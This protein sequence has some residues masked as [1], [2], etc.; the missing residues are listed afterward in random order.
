MAAGTTL[1]YFT[2]TGN[3]LKVARDVA[4]ELGDA[5]LISIPRAGE[6]TVR[7]KAER[8]GIVFPTYFGG[9][10]LIVRSFIERLETP[11]YVFA[12]TT[13]GG[14]SGGSLMQADRLL[15]A[16]GIHLAAGFA[17]NM[18]GNYT[19]LYGA[20]SRKRQQ[21]YFAAE[22]E[23]VVQIGDTVRGKWRAKVEGNFCLF[24]WLFAPLYHLYFARHA[25]EL[26]SRFYADEKCNGCG[27]CVRVCPRADIELVEERPHWLGRCEQ[28]Y[29]CLQWCPQ[30][31]IQANKRTP[32]RKRY[33]NP[34]VALIDIIRA[35]EQPADPPAA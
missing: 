29:A 9:L 13:C 2:A 26:D 4:Q 35:N 28:C 33:H 10:P 14:F 24:R 11:G 31:A 20:N 22:A 1:Y 21:K 16:R 8:V 12:I 32:N 25:R 15:T 6:G 18:P 23:R 27:V 34:K 5:E 30:E 17:V 3:S 7:P 19:R